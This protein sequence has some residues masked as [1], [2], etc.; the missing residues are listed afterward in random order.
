MKILVIE[1]EAE[2]REQVIE[3]L[4]F[5]GYEAF[6]AMNGRQGVELA[7]ISSPDLIISDISMPELDGYEVLLEMQKHPQLKSVPFIF[8]TARTDKSFIR[9]GME[10]GADDYL[11][12]PF[13]RAE[14]LSAV[15]ARLARHKTI[16]DTMRVEVEEIKAK[17]MRLVSHELKTPLASLTFVQQVIERQL[18]QLSEAELADMIQKMRVGTDRLQHVVQQIIYLMQIENGIL[19]RDSVRELG[20]E[21]YLSQVIPAAIDLAR[22]YAYRNHNGEIKL[23]QRDMNAVVWGNALLLKHAITEFLTNALNFS[24]EDRAITL[25][26]WKSEGFV[27]V[28][29]LDQGSGMSRDEVAKARH[30]F[31][32]IGREAKEQQGFGIGMLV[33]QRIIEIHGG[34]LQMDSVVGKGT[35]VTFSLPMITTQQ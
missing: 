17:I 19:T 14:L 11:L 16:R 13:T 6:G 32:Q 22:R 3:M 9:H 26:E 27:W 7:S 4:I 15:N 35:Q 23:D 1:D 21:I 20:N 34:S 29:L 28:S 31:E 33:A 8:L 5:E 2:I 12:K 30:G 24:Q 10:L 25:N 18:G